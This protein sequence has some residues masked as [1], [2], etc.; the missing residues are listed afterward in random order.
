MRCSAVLYCAVL[1][2]A[3]SYC[4]FLICFLWNS[5]GC[6]V[7]YVLHR[8]VL[9][10]AMLRYLMLCYSILDSNALC[11]V[12]C[13]VLFVLMREVLHCNE[14]HFIVQSSYTL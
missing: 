3:V 5:E 7:L 12:Y 1:C 14:L 10:Y 9:R 11:A 2:Y 4:S 6:A 8:I 13:S